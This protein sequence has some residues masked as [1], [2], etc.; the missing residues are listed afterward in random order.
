MIADNRV[1]H[2]N[3]GVCRAPGDPLPEAT[4][5]KHNEVETEP[6]PRSKRRI[7]L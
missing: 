2:V 7:S 4:P 3:T 6:V 1:L 5:R